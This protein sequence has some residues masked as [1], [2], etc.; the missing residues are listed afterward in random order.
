MRVL[1]A[2][3]L[4]GPFVSACGVADPQADETD[5]SVEVEPCEG[6]GDPSVSLG[7]GGRNNFLPLVDG[8]DLLLSENSSGNRGFYIEA[9]VSGID[10]R[11]PVNLVYRVSVGGGATDDYLSRV[12]LVCDDLEGWN[13]AFL[14][15]DDDIDTGVL[16]GASIS[17]IAVVTDDLGQAANV[18]LT[19]DG[20]PTW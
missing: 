20:K 18:E 14:E 12:G 16:E 8:D 10:M 17:I 4:L 3:I 11:E 19:V 2:F 9:M 13:K 1:W 15:F 6:I 5:S 7:T